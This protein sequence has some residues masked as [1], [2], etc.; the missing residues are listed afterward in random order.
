[1]KLRAINPGT[2]GLFGVGGRPAPYSNGMLVE[3]PYGLLFV[4]GQVA[5]DDRGRIVGDD[6]EAQ[7]ERALAN[8]LAVLAEAGA[9][10]GDVIRFGAF[11]T[12]REYVAPYVA[13]RER[14]FPGCRPASTTVI[15]DLV[16][17]AML[18]EVEAVAAIPA[19]GAR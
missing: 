2:I 5:F 18:I 6:I 19:E 11:L 14:L 17:P 15:C 8:L 13:A 9:G 3:G 1:M 4:S 10:P 16:D 12:S 7:A